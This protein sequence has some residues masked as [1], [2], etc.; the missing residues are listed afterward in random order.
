MQHPPDTISE[1]KNNIGT[2]IKNI[3]T[4]TL[5]VAVSDSHAQI[6]EMVVTCR[7][8]KMYISEIRMC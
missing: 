4:E 3:P 2:Q 5:E 7:V 8:S 6:C 1:L